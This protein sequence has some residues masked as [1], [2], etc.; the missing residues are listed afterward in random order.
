[1]KKR[2][3]QPSASTYT[4]LLNACSTSPWNH[5]G[6]KRLQG[7]REIMLEKGY[8]P[9]Q[10]N[11]HAMIKGEICFYLIIVVYLFLLFNK[12]I[13]DVKFKLMFFFG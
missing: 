3:L 13:F 7:L 2:G 10:K 9:N 4:S 12:L 8:E 6:L 5:D 11:Y 1:M